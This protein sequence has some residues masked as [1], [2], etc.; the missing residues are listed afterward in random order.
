MERIALPRIRFRGR[1][2]A[3]LAGALAAVALA[4]AANDVGASVPLPEVAITVTPQSQEVTLDWDEVASTEGRAVSNITFSQWDDANSS[5][6][7]IAGTYV[8]DCDYRLRISKIP[9]DPGFNRRLQL[10][11]QIFENTTGTGAPLRLD[12]LRIVAADSVHAVDPAVAADLGIR[13]SDNIGNADGPLGTVPVS[14]RGVNSTLEVSAGYFVTAL[15]TVTS[16]AQGLSVQ[17]VGPVN[18][19]AIPDPLPPSI[20][21]DTLLVTS[22]AQTFE[23]M[24]AMTISFGEGAAAPGD[25]AKWTAH[26]A[27]PANARI[28]ADLEAFEG[29]HV[30]RSDLPDVNDFTLLGEIQQCASKF[31][32]VL[33]DEAEA[34]ALDVELVYDPVA[35]HFRFVD[36]DVHDDFP[37]RYAVSTFDRGFL[38]NLED[39]TFEGALVS[40]GKLY[41]A[42]SARVREEEIS[43]V[44]NPFKVASDFQEGGPK[45]VFANLPT[46]CT[47][48]VFTESAEHLVTLQHG[49]GEAHSTSPTSREWDLR[50]GNGE[51]IVPGIYIFHVEGTDRYER[52]L[53]GGGTESVTEAVEQTGKMIVIR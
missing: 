40:S 46:E 15:N 9:Q 4:G 48:R 45:V 41:P 30:W 3:R 39:L 42:K 36:H 13:I 27:F 19:N 2:P 21:V 49:P 18:L 11:L 44:P 37:Y 34:A 28:T 51:R 29:Y 16:L 12:T 47:I 20:P 25:T 24:D 22:P 23:I 8:L 53:D 14:L 43:V 35:R 17:V 33:V 5:D 6:F 50:T 1:R 31:D 7:D 10:V 26:Y 52:A 32:F 38:G